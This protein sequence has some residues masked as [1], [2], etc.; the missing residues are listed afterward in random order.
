M[1]AAVENSHH[2]LPMIVGYGTP[3]QEP[4]LLEAGVETFFTHPEDH[5]LVVD[6]P[7]LAVRDGDTVLMAQPGLLSLADMRRLLS[8]EKDAGILFQVV[9]HDPVRLSDDS[10]IRDFRRQKARGKMPPMARTTGRPP[11]ITYTAG[12]AAAI[13]RAWHAVPRRKPADVARETDR[14]LS[15]PDGTIQTW[16][17]RDLVKKFVGTAARD[18]PPEWQGI[19]VAD[20]SGS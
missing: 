6:R 2:R 7:G 18:A 11:Q 4:R 19:D 16:W 5:D 1:F 3:E 15:L 14:L 9:G 20:C 10:A 13:I 12:Q 8:A 17:V